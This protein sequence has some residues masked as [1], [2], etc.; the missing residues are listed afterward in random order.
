MR[1]TSLSGPEAGR[2][3]IVSGIIRRLVRIFEAEPPH[4][5]LEMQDGGRLEGGHGACGGWELRLRGVCLRRRQKIKW[6]RLDRKV[7]T[8][9]WR[10]VGRGRDRADAG[11]GPDLWGGIGPCVRGENWSLQKKIPAKCHIAQ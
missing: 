5:A 11:A 9:A 3:T 10:G 1:C 8:G 2:V 7:G 6:S 4:G